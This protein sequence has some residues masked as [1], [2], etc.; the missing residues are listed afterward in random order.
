L[1][2]ITPDHLD[3]YPDF[4]AYAK[5][6]ARIF[7]N[8]D[9]ENTAVI[10]AADRVVAALAKDIRSRRCAFN[11][12]DPAPCGAVVQDAGI[13]IK[14][15]E[16]GTMTIPRDAIPLTGRHNLENTAA[17]V[18]A[19]IAA[20]G[21]KE[22]VL[23]AISE[24]TPDP[25]RIEWVDTIKGVSFFDD[26]KGTNVDA[27]ARA[28]E[29][30]DGPVIL[31]A[32]G[33]DKLGGYD[34]LRKPVKEHVKALITL[35]EAAPAISRSLQDLVET[36]QVKSMEEAVRLSARLATPGDCVLLSPA[37][38]SFDMYENYAARGID[39]QSAVRRLKGRG[40]A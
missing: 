9:H 29:S 1:L 3:R 30:M 12:V 13:Q 35:G 11:A 23:A 6:K 24:F 8:Q 18:L 38:S 5:S 15:P 39:F 2:N 19:A 4:Q 26:S 7:E 37:C 16:I 32:G 33:R 34:A 36:R 10:N 21:T 14:M 40:D 25:H 27:V 22:G 17:A 31:I 20:G 28:I